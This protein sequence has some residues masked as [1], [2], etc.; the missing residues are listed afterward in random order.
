MY[1]RWRSLTCRI[2]AVK[3]TN[4]AATALRSWWSQGR[5]QGECGSAK[6]GPGTVPGDR[7]TALE[8][9]RR[10]KK[11]GHQEQRQEDKLTGHCLH[12]RFQHPN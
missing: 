4:K 7:V 11:P 2:V 3:P 10:L 8:H 9:I 12:S 5:G 6:H 1:D